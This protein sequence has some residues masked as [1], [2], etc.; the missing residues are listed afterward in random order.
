MCYWWMGLH[1]LVEKDLDIAIVKATNH[2]ESPPKERH[3]RSEF[4]YLSLFIS[5]LCAMRICVCTIW[6]NDHVDLDC[7]D[8]MLKLIHIYMFICQYEFLLFDLP[9]YRKLLGFMLYCFTVLD[10]TCVEFIALLLSFLIRFGY[11]F[12]LSLYR[13]FL[14]NIGGTSSGR[15]GILH[16]RTFQEIVK[17]K[18]LDCNV[19]LSLRQFLFLFIYQ[20]EES[21]KFWMQNIII[22]YNVF[23]LL[24]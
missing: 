6:L 11:S 13:N 23:Y 3:V 20:A 5:L 24:L 1:D 7:K 22:F 16:S 17:D 4:I 21:F 19:F 15:C 14:C 12:F 10:W 9:L 8:S 18:E 2:V